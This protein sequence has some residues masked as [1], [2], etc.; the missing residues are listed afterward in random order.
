MKAWILIKCILAL[1]L[2]AI[3]IAA[4]IRMTI[5]VSGMCKFVGFV[6]TFVWLRYVLNFYYPLR[7]Q[8]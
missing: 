8:S 1:L 7:W 3:M 4:I 2:G 5:G 6:S